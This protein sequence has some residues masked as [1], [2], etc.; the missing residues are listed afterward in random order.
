MALSVG[1]GFTPS[2]PILSP[3]SLSVTS[4]CCGLVGVWG[5]VDW[6]PSNTH[7]SQSL[8]LSRHLLRPPSSPS[9]YCCSLLPPWPWS[10]KGAWMDDG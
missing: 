9:S 10:F 4:A 5:V 3:K 1:M 2:P 7:P 8:S 6:T